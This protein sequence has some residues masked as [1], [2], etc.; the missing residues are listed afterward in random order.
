ME[1]VVEFCKAREKMKQHALATHAEKLESTEAKR[2]I[3]SMLQE[4]MVRH[5]VEC[6]QLPG[7]G[8]T[9]FVTMTMP[10][11]KKKPLKTEEDVLSLV[12]GVADVVASTASPHE[13]ATTV[14][15][16]VVSQLKQREQEGRPPETKVA[17]VSRPVRENTVRLATI[18]AEV[19]H[20]TEQFVDNCHTSKKI[21]ESMRPLKEAWKQQE[22]MALATFSDPVSVRMKKNDTE[23]DFRIVKCQRTK[24]RKGP[25]SI[26]VRAVLT[27][28]R[29]SVDQ[30]CESGTS[31]HDAVSFEKEF[32]DALSQNVK[33]YIASKQEC[34]PEYFLKMYKK[35]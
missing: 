6:I 12:H 25:A 19:R 32:R 16:F 8:K 33:T 1:P 5:N 11:A 21:T 20:L 31:A 26:G 9:S 34:E 7:I 23:V 27:L 35:R 29:D 4:S 10:K 18:P 22:K 30:V 14:T 15:T 2:A 13:I 24:R 3:M 17:I 28:C